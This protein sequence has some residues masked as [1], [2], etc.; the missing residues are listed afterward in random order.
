[1]YNI[2]R[3][4][5]SHFLSFRLFALTAVTA[6]A[7]SP[8]SSELRAK[9]LQEVVVTGLSRATLIRENPVPI[10]SVRAVTIDRTIESN[11]I[12]VLVKN[13]PGLNAVKT[14]PNIS[15][16]LIRGLGY[17]RV[18]TLYDGL[19]QEGQQWGD[20]H[21]I[22]VDTY[23][24]EKAEIIKGPAS[25]QFG[26]DALAG[27]VSLFPH[28]PDQKDGVL[29][30]K[31]VSEYQGNN[32]LTG[33]G[34]RIDHSGG[35]WLWALSGSWRIA[36]NYT[37][38]AD[39]R[40][41][42]AGF[43]EKNISA[44]IGY[45]GRKGYSHLNLTAY[46]N[47]QGIPDG[48]RDS[49]TRRFTRQIDEGSLDDIAHRPLV[50]DAELN[51]YRLSPLHQHIQHYRVYTNNHYRVGATGL[52]DV[53]LGFQQN[54]RREYS[55]P[56]APAQ[57]GLFVRLNTF[58]YGIRYSVPVSVDIEVT[59]GVNGMVQANKSKLA[60]DF[61]IPDYRLADLGGYVFGK[62]R[63]RK[64]TVSGGLRNDLRWIGTRDLYIRRD[65][66]SG[67]AGQ[68]F[69]PDTVGAA[70]Q[71]SSF[72]KTF[73]GISLSLGGTY[74]LTENISIKANLARGYRSPSIT[75]LASNGLDP[76]AH[77]IYLG[78]RDFVPEFS[79]QQ[80]LGI[81]VSLTDVSSS[82][83]V[84][85]NHVQHYIYLS[86]LTDAQGDPL[87]DA[88]GNK[89][90]QYQQAAAQLY[91]M[92]ASL[93]LHPERM[94]GFQWI[95]GLS[96]LYGI[97]KK[98]EY[99]GQGVNGGFLPLMPPLKLTSSVSQDIPVRSG[100][101]PTV[102]LQADVEYNAAQG[103][104]LALYHSETPTPGYTLIN[105]SVGAALGILKD[106]PWQIQAQ[107][108]NLFDAIY[109]SNLS[110]LKY[111]EYYSRSPDGRSGI[112]GM[113]RNVCIKLIVPFVKNSLIHAGLTK[114][115]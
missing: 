36:G 68:V 96:L 26:S 83:S 89:T 8:D 9:K 5:L 79:L 104:Y 34:L 4:I 44:L 86:Q 101:L 71:F 99:K 113:G 30:G 53:L 115:P 51:A 60:T 42:N 46:D 23:T 111:F 67:F 105:I 27:V 40:V 91:G 62:W 7:Q 74:Q 110:R 50:T 92:E 43:S 66:V 20:E 73:M 2:T 45:A 59:A 17:N 75:E 93:D 3:G 70:R 106:A 55:H 48:S 52:I 102:R 64:W 41:Y 21:G 57:P 28:V 97:N 29:R 12:D 11:A 49:L 78:N 16:P 54:I 6:N 112:Y 77:I 109:Q 63:H 24:I 25:L 33:N 13:V 10:A 19:R 47:L 95:S 108:N 32:G 114:N 90:F 72:S 85:S 82:V 98:P 65:P 31:Y 56:T 58:N 35:H 88:Q 100:L 107:V 1:M 37:D 76:G 22:E 87:T 69:L 38:K 81:S 103:R 61:P 18:L 80:D 14:G 39:G 84:F 94:K 15:K